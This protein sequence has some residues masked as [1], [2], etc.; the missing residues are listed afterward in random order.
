MKKLRQ[1]SLYLF[2][3]ILTC[4]AAIVGAL[5]F[6]GTNSN[7]QGV[8]MFSFGITF[9][10]FLTLLVSGR[11]KK[12]RNGL[13]P[14]FLFLVM[15]LISAYA[16]NREIQIFHVSTNW[17]N[18]LLVLSCVNYIAIFWYDE[19]P[20]WL[21]LAHV[22]IISVSLLLFVYLSLYL[23]PQYAFS[24]FFFWVLFLPMHSF[25]PLLLVIYSI[26]WLVKA[27]ENN[28]QVAVSIWSG[29][30]LVMVFIIAYVTA[31]NIRVNAINRHYRNADA[32]PSKSLPVWVRTAS[33]VPANWLTERILKTDSRFGTSAIQGSNRNWFWNAPTIRR[34]NEFRH[35]PLITIATAFNGHLIMPVEER[36]RILQAVF[37][38]RHQAEERLWSGDDLYTEEVNSTIQIWPQY[39]I[40]YTDMVIKVRCGYGE[41]RWRPEEEAIYSFSLPEGSAVT[42]LSLWVDGNEMPGILTTKQKA[43]SAYRTIVGRE[44][45]D[46]S[47][48]HWQEGNRVSVRVFPVFPGK[49]RRFRV[50]ITTPL[51]IRKGKLEYRNIGMEGPSHTLAQKPVTL[52]L[53]G[54]VNELELPG[55]F[56]PAQKNSYERKGRSGTDWSITMSASRPVSPQAFSFKGQ[57]Y[58]VKDYVH[59]RAHFQPA[60]V[61]LDLNKA[62]TYDEYYWALQLPGHHKTFVCRDEQLVEVTEKNKDVLFKELHQ[63]QFSLFPVHQ[64]ANVDTALLISKSA[65]SSPNLADL[66]ETKFLDSL[67]AFATPRPRLRLFCIDGELSPYLRSLKEYRIFHFEQG[68]ID[69]CSLLMARE[70][71]SMDAEDENQVVID[72]SRMMITRS[73]D[74]TASVAPD[75]LMRLFAYNH[76]MQQAGAGL[77]NG[78]AP[79]DSLVA[80][81]AEAH[82]VTPVSSLVVLES[83]KD[84]DRFDIK[85]TDGLKNAAKSST[86]AV[87]EPHE[88]ALI[89]L[90][91]FLLFTLK[92]GPV[93]KRRW[94]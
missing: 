51:Q 7:E 21:K 45:R 23:V 71:F 57:A 82:V 87:P 69:D 3:L 27:S 94:S 2:G 75:H 39:R 11:L 54:P 86:G 22:F 6:F 43:D 16:L 68:S 14:F 88:W 20:C 66:K 10:F 81:A 60:H 93:W 73:K 9:I 63:Q 26:K 85:E 44:A 8:F 12:G 13:A 19:M 56:A 52:Q 40:S 83:Q 53:M 32:D 25:V 77:L 47:V 72:H 18:V 35:D 89:I 36:L 64:I 58:N 78:E 65:G 67:K 29:I 15:F 1:D 92:F 24:A 28:K 90:A 62:W 41:S 30:G 49:Y 55:G 46:P 61:Y 74:S 17:L 79:A 80:E 70:E 42:A 59:H 48:L 84:Y 37:N 91:V 5:P 50:G 4:I 33:K 34:S 76:V 38:E 31:W